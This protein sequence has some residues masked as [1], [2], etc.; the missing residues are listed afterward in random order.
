MHVIAAAAAASAPFVSSSRN[1]LVETE[2]DWILHSHAIASMGHG[3]GVDLPMNHHHIIIELI[4][5]CLSANSSAVSR[6]IL[7]KL[8][9]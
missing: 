6:P 5:G 4:F 9:H 1:K 8:D 7:T 3:I 2:F